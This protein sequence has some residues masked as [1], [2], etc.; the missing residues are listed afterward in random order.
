MSWYKVI[1]LWNTADTFDKHLEL[2]MYIIMSHTHSFS[3]YKELQRY[4]TVN[5]SCTDCFKI[6]P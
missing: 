5:D 2:L 3:I 4:T 1:S 6:V